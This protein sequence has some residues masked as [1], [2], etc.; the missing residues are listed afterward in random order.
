MCSHASSIH[1]YCDAQS[2]QQTDIH[3]VSGPVPSR[4]LGDVGDFYVQVHL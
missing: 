3:D 1:S 4:D 2:Y